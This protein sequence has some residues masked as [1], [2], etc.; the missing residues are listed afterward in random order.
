MLA[1]AKDLVA[2]IR[3]VLIILAVLLVLLFPSQVGAWLAGHGVH[4]I[5]FEGT[6]V[7][8]TQFDNTREALNAVTDAA[9]ALDKQPQLQASLEQAAGKLSQTLANQVRTISR[10]NPNEVPGDGWMYLGTLNNDKSGWRQGVS[11]TVQGTWPLKPGDDVTLA[12][13][14]NL[15]TDSTSEE[16]PNSRIISV[17]PRGTKVH[18]YELDDARAVPSSDKAAPGYRAWAKV[19]V[20]T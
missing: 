6:T 5:G 4:Q 3:E 1:Q 7:D 9:N 19:R 15:H 13:D 18:I 11:P 17:L 12:T 8:L 2:V 14:T 10:S 20:I 16:R